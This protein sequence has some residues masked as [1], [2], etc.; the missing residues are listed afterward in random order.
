MSNESTLFM[1][2]KRDNF[3][4]KKKKVGSKKKN[5]AQGV[6]SMMIFNV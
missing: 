4:D 3:S 2:M 6:K 5:I 1:A